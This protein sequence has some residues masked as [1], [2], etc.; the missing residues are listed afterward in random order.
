MSLLSIIPNLNNFWIFITE[1]QAI[2]IIAPLGGLFV[3]KVG[4]R[5]Q[6]I[7]PTHEVLSKSDNALTRYDTYCT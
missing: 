1:K 3:W 7:N 6:N 2:L 4:N 5:P